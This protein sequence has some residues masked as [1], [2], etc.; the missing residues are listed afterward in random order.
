ML[1][2]TPAGLQAIQEAESSG[3]KIKATHIAIG[4]GGGQTPD[5]S[6]S[7][8]LVNELYRQPIDTIAMVDAPD[9]PSG[10]VVEFG[11]SIHET[12][13]ETGSWMIREVA[14]LAGDTVIGIGQHP[15]L[16]KVG[17]DSPKGTMTHTITAPMVVSNEAVISLAIAPSV[18]A[19]MEALSD[20]NEDSQAHQDIREACATAISEHN[21]NDGAHEDIR[22]AHQ[23]AVDEIAAQK[24]AL[25][26]LEE[27]VVNTG[28]RQAVLSYGEGIS[29]E[30]TEVKGM[31][32]KDYSGS[33]GVK[34]PV[35]LGMAFSGGE[36]GGMIMPTSP[37]RMGCRIVL[38]TLRGPLSVLSTDSAGSAQEGDTTRLTQFTQHGYIT[39][40]SLR[41]NDP[42]FG[43]NVLA[44][45]TTC[46]KKMGLNDL[47]GKL[48]DLPDS[49][50]G[51]AF[52]YFEIGE[53]RFVIVPRKYDGKTHSIDSHIYKWNGSAF[54][55]F[56]S[57]PTKG[58]LWA[59]PFEMEGEYYLLIC[60]S[61]ADGSYKQNSPLL[62]W[63][64]NDFVEIH[65][66]TTTGAINANYFEIG[67]TKF[68]AIAFYRAP[69]GNPSAKSTIYKW[70]GS[71]FVEFQS[72][73]TKDCRQLYHFCM[74]GVPY[75]GV[76]NFDPSLESLIYRWDGTK[77]VQ[78]Q[79]VGPYGDMKFEYFEIEGESFIFKVN[80]Y[81]SG[82]YSINS[83]VLRWD[84]AK[85]V[86]HQNISTHGAYKANHLEIH[87][88]HYVVVTCF[89]GE[90][91]YIFKW[92]RHK[93]EFVEWKT[94]P[95]TYCYDARF[96]KMEKSY[97]IGVANNGIS[98]TDYNSTAVIHKLEEVEF[99]FNPAN[100]FSMAKLRGIDRDNVISHPTDDELL[101]SVIKRLDSVGS[102]AFQ[103]FE[104]NGAD[105]L[106]FDGREKVTTGSGPIA[107]NF[108]DKDFEL[109][110]SS[111]WA[112]A[113]NGHYMMYSF[114]G[115]RLDNLHPGMRGKRG[116]TAFVK[117]VNGKTI[118][119]GFPAETVIVRSMDND[120]DWYV[121]CRD[122]GWEKFTML[123]STAPE[124][125]M[126]YPISV[127]GETI[128]LPA[129]WTE[130]TYFVMAFGKMGGLATGKSIQIKATPE[131]PFVATLA[132]GF[133]PEG[134]RDKIIHKD[135]FSIYPQ[136]EPD[137]RYDLVLLDNGAVDLIPEK[138]Y[139]TDVVQWKNTKLLLG[140]CR[141]TDGL[142]VDLDLVPVGDDYETPWFPVEMGTRYIL[143]NL[144]K[145]AGIEFSIWWNS[146]PSNEGSREVEAISYAYNTTGGEMQAGA[147]KK[148]S[149][150]TIEVATAD[151]YVFYSKL[152]ADIAAAA[153]GF[154]KL[155]VKRNY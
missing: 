42:E 113:L 57:I 74:D 39:S 134:N 6:G 115:E 121:M 95:T 142:I 127:A 24:E 13:P 59:E 19:T 135:S 132:K 47:A 150:D 44:F 107:K 99:N 49:G 91:S 27:K 136:N 10:K 34:L 116:V 35:D 93:R 80:H 147:F 46:K 88:E 11:V 123:N 139:V 17:K 45:N 72:F 108:T 89:S 78:Q 4:D 87:G 29:V 71:A 84:G 1:R 30:A 98:S 100:G 21:R 8:M 75:L 145:F 77:F 53:D 111:V 86:T 143:P 52:R 124:G 32:S 26:V 66:F 94:F 81:A 103:T 140:S 64:G 130:D 120:G 43:N 109:G 126:T 14:I 37:S 117:A 2:W 131:A 128:T 9:V 122:R 151:G 18:H 118:N 104:F 23:A 106:R 20:H 112:N 54:E 102:W 70:D 141:I 36:Y 67:E 12:K 7:T 152:S 61:Y 85:F 5:H 16:E 40:H 90:T 155:V 48:Q 96:F 58:A 133:G 125:T 65:R 22:Q 31:D 83:N 50:G 41:S 33:E 144:F 56:K 79:S 129:S 28:V 51:S 15:E 119:I 55:I 25:E 154:Y 38:D 73:Q 82:N 148:R 63:N 3:T 146:S 101:V 97:Y 149:T 68:L 110:G 69:N 76:V 153:T 62:K 138:S 137:G 92:N 60:N 105:Y 114:Y